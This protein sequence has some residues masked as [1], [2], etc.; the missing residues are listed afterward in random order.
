M[1]DLNSVKDV[2]KK[3]GTV[4]YR[5]NSVCNLEKV[6]NY[7]FKTDTPYQVNLAK[8]KYNKKTGEYEGDALYNDLEEAAKYFIEECRKS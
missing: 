3:G 5:G 4:E 1:F 2:V 6:L 8:S 7:P